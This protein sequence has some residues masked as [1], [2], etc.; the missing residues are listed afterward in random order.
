MWGPA[1]VHSHWQTPPLV[2]WKTRTDE[3]MNTLPE[4][5]RTQLPPSS[6]IR[7]PETICLPVF[8]SVLFCGQYN[9]RNI[10][11]LIPWLLLGLTPGMTPQSLVL[12]P[13]SPGRNFQVST[14]RYGPR[15][16]VSIPG[17]ELAKP[18]LAVCLVMGLLSREWP[19]W[20]CCAKLHY[21]LSRRL[22]LISDVI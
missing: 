17:E 13:C 7:A 21:P 18:S 15:C 6:V 14:N 2:S 16:L 20:A 8:W 3:A 5:L 19:S 4:W 1:L 12:V 11:Y 10:S 9:R 22:C